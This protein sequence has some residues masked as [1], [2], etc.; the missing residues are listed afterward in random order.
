MGEYGRKPGPKFVELVVAPVVAE[1]ALLG[2]RLP[3]DADPLLGAVVPLVLGEEV[4]LARLLGVTAARDDVHDRAPVRQLVERRELLGGD[5]RVDGVRP[6]RDD[7]L[8]ALGRR[9]DGGGDHERVGPRAAVGHQRVVEPGILEGAGVAL[10]VGGIQRTATPARVELVA[11]P[12][13]D[14]TDE[15]DGHDCSFSKTRAAAPSGWG[16]VATGRSRW[17]DHWLHEPGY[18]WGAKPA[19]VRATKAW[20]AVMPEPQ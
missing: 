11:L 14:R 1:R 19:R 4:A 20:D 9:G 13:I 6:H 18:S 5:R 7:G 16:P 17:F 10:E 12:H 15:L 8:D 3:D 2:P